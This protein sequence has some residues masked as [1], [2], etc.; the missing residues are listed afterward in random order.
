MDF[1]YDWYMDAY[2]TVRQTAGESGN[3]LLTELKQYE[4]S[5]GLIGTFREFVS[6]IYA[7]NRLY[8]KKRIDD[9]SKDTVKVDTQT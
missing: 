1:W 9:M 8:N 2:D 7:I 6:I 3:I 4:D 5:F